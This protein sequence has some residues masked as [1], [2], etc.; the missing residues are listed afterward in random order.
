MVIYVIAKAHSIYTMYYLFIYSIYKVPTMFILFDNPQTEL[1]LL[2]N[3]F[4]LGYQFPAA[5]EREVKSMT[6]KT[7]C[8]TFICFVSIQFNFR[9]G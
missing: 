8:S 9:S 4:S 2:D 3:C 5:K 1:R 7:Q 6:R